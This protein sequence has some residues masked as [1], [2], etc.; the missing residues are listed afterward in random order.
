MISESLVSWQLTT[1]WSNVGS[2]AICSCS[3]IK[4]SNLTRQG[5]RS[6]NPMVVRAKAVSERPTA[7]NDRQ[8]WGVWLYSPWKSQCCTHIAL[9]HLSRGSS[10]ASSIISMTD[11][12]CHACT[13]F[14]LPSTNH[15]YSKSESRVRVSL[16]RPTASDNQR[17]FICICLI[18]R[19]SWL[20]SHLR[21][22]QHDNA[23]AM[24]VLA[25]WLG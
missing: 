9:V 17:A 5:T 23:I 10:S 19:L 16:L 13:I 6:F 7:Y 21:T 24:P 22:S 3:I 25:G 14:Q 12:V 4:L 8:W 15:W 2:R 18:G 11:E 1:Y 20:R